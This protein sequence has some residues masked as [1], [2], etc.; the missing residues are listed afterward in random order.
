MKSFGFLWNLR[1]NWTT[2]AEKHVLTIF[3]ID[4]FFYILHFIICILRQL[5]NFAP[6]EKIALRK[7]TNEAGAKAATDILEF[8]V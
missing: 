4:T 3:K 8:V 1:D 2:A 5:N 6:D 7:V